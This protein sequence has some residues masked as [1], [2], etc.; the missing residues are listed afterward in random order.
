M[1]HVSRQVVQ[2]VQTLLYP[3]GPY[4]EVAERIRILHKL[5]KDFRL[6]RVE[7]LLVRNKWI[8]RAFITVDGLQ[9]VG[10]AEIH[11]GAPKETPD[12]TN[13]VTC[14]QTSAV[15]NALSFAGYGDLR[16][17]LERQKLDAEEGKALYPTEPP[18]GEIEGIRV[19]W[20]DE[21]PYVPVV[22]RLYHL[23]KLNHTMSI[24]H[25]EVVQVHGV[26]VYRVQLRVNEHPYIGDAEVH[27][28]APE[29]APEGRFP[30]STAQTSAVGNALAQAGFGDVRMLL[31]RM[32]KATEQV[33]WV[34]SLASADAVSQAKRQRQASS[35]GATGNS[36]EASQTSTT[37]AVPARITTEQM[38]TI[39]D[40]SAKLGESVITYDWTFAEAETYIEI[41]RIQVDE[42]LSTADE[43]LP[44]GKNDAS[45]QQEAL[46]NYT[47]IGELKRAWMQAFNIV[48]APAEIRRQWDA[49]KQ[50]ECHQAVNDELMQHAQYLLLKN[51]IGQHLYKKAMQQPS[52][53]NGRTAS[54]SGR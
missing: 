4:V 50:R 48:G 30:V 39:R 51:A 13:P 17:L 8:Y 27:F 26:W 9:H 19:V 25:C 11:F 35:S 34:P 42:L 40:L 53:A 12:G 15:G 21:T 28:A 46:A 31:E 47:E 41:L 20:L 16:L 1:S 10:D 43:T 18:Y 52:G 14:G 32:G 33:L 37:D 5:G 22:E 45:F 36:M 29:T 2:G 54:K 44:S 24:D 6:Q 3:D 7:T 23:Y 38:E 49:F